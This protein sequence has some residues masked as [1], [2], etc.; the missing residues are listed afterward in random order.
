MQKSELKNYELE[1]FGAHVPNAFTLLENNDAAKY[2]PELTTSMAIKY[3]N[4]NSAENTENSDNIYSD[5]K[6]FDRFEGDVYKGT[7]R[8]FI[9]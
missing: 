3:V 4:I 5:W 9:T 1:L 8:N 6:R 7:A 2:L